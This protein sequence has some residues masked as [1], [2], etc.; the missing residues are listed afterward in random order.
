MSEQ[1]EFL[2]T[3]ADARAAD[4][5]AEAAG[6]PVSRL[7]EQAGRA[8]AA[9]LAGSRWNGASVAIL[10]GPGNN[11]GDGYVAAR[12]LA[13]RGH[14]VEVFSDAA[15]KDGAAAGMARLWAGPVHP[16]PAFVPDGWD[17]TLDALYGSGLNRAIEG[18]AAE[19]ILRLNA[20]NSHVIAVDVPSGLNGDSGQP[21][22]PVVEADETITFFAAR[23]G[24]W[25][26]PGRML[27]GA[28]Q[29]AEI[30][31]DHTHLDA[32]PRLFRN[33][34]ALW[35]KAIS[36]RDPASHKYRN[37]AVLVASG[38]E[39]RTGAAR[40]SAQAALHAG[41]G[42]VTLSGDPAALRIH[43]SQVT[44]IMLREA[45]GPSDFAGLLDENRFDSVVIGP[46][47]GVD[48]PTE[49]RLRALL[50]RPLPAVLDADA[51]TVLAGKSENFPR[52]GTP[53]RVLTPHEGEFSRLFGQE[54][55]KDPTYASLPPAL[56][57]S[58]V[59]KA[60]AAS[61]LCGEIVVCKGPD[62]VIAAPDGRAA[63]N[64]NA[65]PELATAGSGDVLAGIIAA[66]LA[67]GMP[68]FEAASAGVWLHGHCGAM[69]GAGLTAERLV[70]RLRPLSAYL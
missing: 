37:G 39:L 11:G 52:D 31:L 5:R 14:R 17:V 2:L 27:C 56:Q 21:T 10:C 3:N 68:A 55:A 69:F 67:T 49:A 15:P 28:L 58:K 60:R 65:G 16:L 63:I 8:I 18:P 44:A 57:A 50:A 36:P 25:L 53:R 1:P 6:L 32:A 54:L 43:A 45:A 29:V 19:A 64:T 66:H 33:T 51:L 41:A 30:G 22:G 24:H 42:A 59:E 7:M 40:L 61:R 4:A 47:A 23:P 70:D 26:W 35:R 46:A 38:P 12:L 9:C 20:G 13:E 34:P 62:S 48:E